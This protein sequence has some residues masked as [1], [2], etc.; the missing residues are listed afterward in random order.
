MTS[1]RTYVVALMLVAGVVCSAYAQVVFCPCLG[2]HDAG[3]HRIQ[4]GVDEPTGHGFGMR[5]AKGNA[6]R[7]CHETGKAVRQKVDAQDRCRA[8]ATCPCSHK[9]CIAV[10]QT[11]GP[12]FFPSRK[13]FDLGLGVSGGGAV[14]GSD[15]LAFPKPLLGVA[16][17]DR[18][19]AFP[20]AIHVQHCIWRC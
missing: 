13:N 18:F 10:S 16:S 6:S 12:A 14:V 1:N 3:A 20:S 19:D 17:F 8:Q 11:A 5:P 15:G 2:K 4:A 9:G 7:C